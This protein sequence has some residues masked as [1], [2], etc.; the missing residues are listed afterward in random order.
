[1][2]KS[3]IARRCKGCG[4]YRRQYH[5]CPTPLST[6][7]DKDEVIRSRIARAERIRQECLSR[8]IPVKRLMEQAGTSYSNYS[9]LMLGTSSDE[10]YTQLEKLLE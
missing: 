10:R 9:N 2:K 3:K 1:M 4:R 6:K 7:P 8:G 5:V